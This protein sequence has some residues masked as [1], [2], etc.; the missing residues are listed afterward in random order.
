ALLRDV[1]F[2]QFHPTAIATS[3]DPM[4]LATEALR[5]EGAFL[6]NG[7]G[8]RFM[9][10][11]P[12]RELAPRGVVARA[13]EAEIAR[14]EAVFLDTRA[15]LGAGIV[16][17]FPAVATL[18]RAGG[19]DPVVQPIPVRPAAHYH[20]GGVAVDERGRST[21]DGLW[22]CGEVAS[23]GLH[24]ADRLAS[25]SLLEA[26]AYAR[27]VARDIA[28]STA[29]RIFN[30]TAAVAAAA[31]SATVAPGMVPSPAGDA[32]VLAALRRLMTR[33]VGVIRSDES[34]RRAITALA[35]TAEAHPRT[36]VSEM[37]L[38]G[39]MVAT[40]ALERRESR[41]AQYRSDFPLP[42]AEAVHT[43]LTLDDV[44]R[45]AA[46]VR[47]ASPATALAQDV[48]QATAGGA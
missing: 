36:A 9:A 27:W 5:G 14:G 11:V 17:R 32:G 38:V 22:A 19:I 41:G 44:R 29:A 15:A 13:I 30:G 31:S 47:G 23:T 21:V 39:L 40:A 12:G 20:M 7:R 10:D 43:E 42:A 48:G 6:V 8:E 3:A 26:L 1:E 24:G 28:A 33:D 34:L 45:H 2:V 25:N 46:G 35:A 16:A 4:P 37:V 18:C